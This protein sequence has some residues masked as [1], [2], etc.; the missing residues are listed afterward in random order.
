MIG[1]ANSPDRE[2]ARQR[3]RCCLLRLRIG[4]FGLA[5]V[6]QSSAAWARAGDPRADAIGWANWSLNPVVIVVAI[7]T[8]LSYGVGAVRR[9]ANAGPNESWRHAAFAGGIVTILLALESPLGAL[10]DHLFLIRQIQDLLLHMVGPMLILLA[11]S[12]EALLAGLPSALRRTAFVRQDRDTDQRRAISQ[13]VHAA[14]PT[15]LFIAALYV[16]LYPPFQD[17]AVLSCPTEA[18]LS[19]TMLVTGIVF[20]GHILDFRPPPVGTSYG[21]R[22]MM[23]WITALAHIGIGAYLTLKGDI[24]YPAYDIMGR[25][26]G[27][28]PLTDETVGGFIIWVPSALICLAAAI[29]VIHLWGRHEDRLS[30]EN[31]GWSPSNA[32]ALLFPT[33]GEA[34]VALAR[35]KNRVMAIGAVA[36]VLAVF[37]FTIATGVLNR[38]NAAAHHG[39]RAHGTS[40]TQHETLR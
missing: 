30:A 17:A 14:A 27:I 36:F 34:L 8:C 33:T 1:A 31:S 23:L 39:L 10:A 29:M 16:W 9:H 40:L 11:A 24:L 5:L 20:W 22:M 2:P 6:L 19:V 3:H 37:G 32:A 13:F 15:A 7:V 12:R 28:S 4:A 25:Q 18:A 38:L 21:S 26:F 35:P